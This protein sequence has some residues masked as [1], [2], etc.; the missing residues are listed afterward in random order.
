MSKTDI[1]LKKGDKV[2]FPFAGTTHIGIF[3]GIEEVK[4]GTI[5]RV[6]HK[7]RDSDGIVYPVDISVI[8][9]F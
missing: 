5:E 1:K 6:Y 2:R 8:D 9:K 3:E 4:Y 7:C